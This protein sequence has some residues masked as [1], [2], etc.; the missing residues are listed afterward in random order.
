MKALKTIFKGAK[1]WWITTLVVIVLFLTITLVVTQNVFLSGTLNSVFGGPQRYLQS[2]DPSIYQYFTPDEGIETKED[3][4]NKANTLNETICEEGI[5]L[6]KNESNALPLAAGSR[7]TV[8]GKN[9][10]NMIYGGSGSGGADT[11]KAVNL[12]DSLRNAGFA[13]NPTIKNFYDDNGASGSGRPGN[14]TMN[15]GAIHF[16]AT[17]ET[18]W[19]SYTT[20]VVN[21]FNEYSDA[22]IVVISRIGGEGFDLP[23]QATSHYLQ[24][25]QNEKDLLANANS[26]FSNVILVVN[27]ATSMELGFLQDGTYPNIKSA[28]WIGTTGLT[29]MNALGKIIKG[30]VNPS[31][32]VVDIYATDFTKDPTW[33][34]FGG[35]LVDGGNIYKYGTGNTRS[36]RYFVYYE[37]GIYVG[38]RYY[39]TRGV[40][41]GGTWYDD[42]VV[43]PFGHGL[44]YSTFE[45]EIVTP[46]AGTA[47]AEDTEISIDV[48]VKNTGT[49]AGKEVVQLYYRSPYTAGGIEKSDVVLGAFAKTNIIAPGETETVTL[50]M[51]AREMASYD[52]EGKNVDGDT[53]YRGYILEAGNYDLMIRANSHDEVAGSGTK[54]L[55]YTLATSIKYDKDDATGATIDNLFDDVNNH[56]ASNENVKMTSRSD[57][58]G[59]FPT[60]GTTK[61]KSF[62]SSFLQNLSYKNDDSE[63]QPWYVA[64]ED[65]PKHSSRDTNVQLYEVKDKEYDDGGEGEKM[66][67]DLLDQITIAEMSNLIG[68]GNFNTKAIESIGKPLTT[69]PDGPAGFTVFMGDPSVYGTCFYA[70]ECII[71]ATWNVELG[72]K[73]GESI[74]NES[75]MGNERGD[76][77]PYSGWYAP[78]MNIH[79]SPFSGRNWEYYS[80]DP[81]LSGKMAANVVQGAN[82][83][84]VYTYLKHFALNDQETNREG[85]LTWAS[86]QSMRE[87]Y[88]RPFELAV[89][90]G[91]SMAMMSSFN[92]I[93]S[94]WAGG[95]RALLTD[96]L[97]DEWGFKGMVITDFN[98]NANYMPADQ[99]IRAGGDLNLCQDI[100]PGNNYT[101]TQ[102]TA[103]RNATRNILYTVSRSNAMN[104]SGEGVVW[105][106]SIPSWMMIVIIVDVSVLALLIGWGVFAILRAFKKEK[107]SKAAPK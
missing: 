82:S 4:F 29:G 80:E 28:L 59:T 53:L 64:P 79:R 56:L 26:R 18:P 99:M 15:G 68:T 32:K 12:Y 20:S 27:C 39:E 86:E 76:G 98:T 14:P 55:T 42:N 93:G 71:A 8:L 46:T 100:Q 31:G 49:V 92:R 6:L 96:L 57:F 19:S 2:G 75:L 13:L 72:T 48:K 5:V 58:A 81:L 88:Y 91:G 41:E 94:T 103:M 61:E 87:I 105:G 67:N 1:A 85:V 38:Y 74:G 43:F 78:A 89:K 63:G 37:E 84:G 77:R 3:A 102:V 97:R 47:L 36:G 21:S 22:A 44:S 11:S 104:G 60:I 10:V 69:D 95:H 101:A 34:N 54:K 23:R 51:T 107:A 45:S 24:L 40:T 16:F 35:N 90:E 62:S 17:G 30:E 70:S 33:Q 65:M 9:S 50:T 25:D 73:M 52:Y 7:I 66:W 106:Y 83:K